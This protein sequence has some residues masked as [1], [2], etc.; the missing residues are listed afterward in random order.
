MHVG[1]AKS[2]CPD[3]KLDEWDVKTVEDF[4]TGEKIQEDQFIGPNSLEKTENEKYLGDIISN[5]GTNTKNILARKGKGLG[6]VNQVMSK[7]EGTVFGPFFFEVGLILRSSNLLNGVLT[8]AEAWYNI[9]PSEIDQLEMVDESLMKRFLEAG[10]CCPSEMLYLETGTMPMRFVFRIRRLMYLHY[11]LNESENSLVNQVLLHQMKNP[12]KNDWINQV[13]NDFK[14]LAISLDTD[15]IKELSEEGFRSFVKEKSSEKALEYLNKLKAKHSKVL[16]IEHTRLEVQPYLCPENV[17][18]VQMCKFIFQARARMLPLRSNFKG[19]YRKDDWNCELGCNSEDNQQ[20]L[21][22]CPKLEDRS[23][24]SSNTPNYQD[25]FSSHLER[26]LQV[27]M[28]LKERMKRR[29]ALMKQ[30]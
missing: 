27:A 4:K 30:A 24:T 13:K 29:N 10:N 19:K 2:Y 14:V 16:H 7:L 9:K 20:H 11:L 3:L 6:V 18:D 1:A 8:N 22:E 21:L 26:Q 5:D 25:L 15:E 28:I 17:I 12:S 23:L